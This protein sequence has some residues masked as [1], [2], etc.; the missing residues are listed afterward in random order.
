MPGVQDSEALCVAGCEGEHPF[1]SA[2]WREPYRRHAV[3]DDYAFIHAQH[4]TIYH[5]KMVEEA[6]EAY[7]MANGLF[8][9]VL[10][11]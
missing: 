2:G 8:A 5:R 6:M 11:L 9:Q 1:S 4:G 10:Q 3:P 7:R